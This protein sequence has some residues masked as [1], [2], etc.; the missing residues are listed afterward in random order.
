MGGAAAGALP[1]PNSSVC[2]HTPCPQKHEL[3][4]FCNCKIH[5]SVCISSCFLL[6]HHASLRGKDSIVNFPLTGII[7]RSNRVTTTFCEWTIRMMFAWRWWTIYFHIQ[8]WSLAAWEGGIFA[9]ESDNTGCLLV[10]SYVIILF[11]I[12]DKLPAISIHISNLRGR[13]RM[14]LTCSDAGKF[15]WFQSQA[16]VHQMLVHCFHFHQGGGGVGVWH[17][18]HHCHCSSPS[19]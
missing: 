17:R 14:T 18:Y 6:L 8:L 11:G 2:T 9:V 3:L 13:G 12:S 7:S 10:L 15:W 4:K 16:S 5:C 1:S 19:L